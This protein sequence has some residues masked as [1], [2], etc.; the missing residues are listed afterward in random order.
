M[1]MNI[2][3]LRS[4]YAAAEEG[5]VIKAAKKLMLSRPI[6]TS[7]VKRLEETI[8][9]KLLVQE[10][11]SLHLTRDGQAVYK[12]VSRVFR[13][14][15]ETEAYLRHI[16]NHKVAAL[17]IGC[18]EM[19]TY[20][21]IQGIVKEF[22]NSHQ[23]VTI[24]INHGKDAAMIKSVEDGKN[25]MA[26]IR[27]RPDRCSLVLEVIDECELV[28]VASPFTEYVTNRDISVKSLAGLP[29]IAIK[30]GFAVREVMNSYFRRFDIKP[31]IV[32]ECSN[33]LLLKELV[34]RD[35][36]VAFIERQLVEEELDKYLLKEIVII[37]GSPIM[38]IA[39]GYPGPREISA[40][41]RTFVHHLQ[42]MKEL[43]QPIA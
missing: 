16:S 18:P 32:Q 3:Q 15:H 8:G 10:G 4:F 41:A 2:N 30:E 36:G 43:H 13:E 24:T 12:R 28:L 1:D 25:D 40:P 31:L 21:R 5:N 37:E 33:V 42:Q 29:F 34:R 19:L 7:H 39:L 9:L 26:L 35:G 20:E 27:Y 17:R 14:I 6:L 22:Q 23:G 38:E 11:N